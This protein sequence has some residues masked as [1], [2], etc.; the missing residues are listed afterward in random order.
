MCASRNV[1]NRLAQERQDGRRF[2]IDR[3]WEIVVGRLVFDPFHWWFSDLFPQLRAISHFEL[4]LAQ[5]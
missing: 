5:G 2:G 4:V 1:R 3:G